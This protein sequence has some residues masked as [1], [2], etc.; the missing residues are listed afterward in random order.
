[1]SSANSYRIIA[2]AYEI[3][4]ELPSF[5]L[6]SLIRS[7]LWSMPLFIPGH[8]SLPR[9]HCSGEWIL[10]RQNGQVRHCRGRS[11]YTVHPSFLSKKMQSLFSFSMRLMIPPPTPLCCF[12]RRLREI[13]TVGEGVDFISGD[14]TVPV[15]PQQLRSGSIQSE[16]PCTRGR[17]S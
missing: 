8:L 10:E 11:A 16:D 14:A 6:V 4:P 3:L 7:A 9:F 15:P 17:Q 12:E 2:V 13:G 1:M 5:S